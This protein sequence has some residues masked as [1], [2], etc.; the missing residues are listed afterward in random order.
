MA[1][2]D[3]KFYCFGN[4]MNDDF[5]FL[6]II[7]KRILVIQGSSA[8]S[9]KHFSAGGI[10]VNERRGCLSESSVEA[11]IVLREAYLNKTWPKSK[12]GLNDAAQNHH[13][14]QREP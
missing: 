7:T 6:S 11:L 8:E 13:D 14:Q 10:I 4:I 2:S 9:E 12:H 1:T 5:Q 3:T